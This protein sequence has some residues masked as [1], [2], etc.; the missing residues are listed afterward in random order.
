MTKALPI[1]ELLSFTTGEMLALK[2]R[3]WI[4]SLAETIAEVIMEGVP[5]PRR[6]GGRR[7]I[8]NH[9]TGSVFWGSDPP[10]EFETLVETITRILSNWTPECREKIEAIVRA[11]GKSLVH[12]LSTA[13]EAEEFAD[14]QWLSGRLVAT[15]ESTT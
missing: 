13:I 3:G 15:S 1:S 12:V 5:G 7:L 6:S 4:P 10:T 9:S 2:R 8:R 14:L 11:R